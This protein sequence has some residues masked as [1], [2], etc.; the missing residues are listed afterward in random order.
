[1]KLRF[2][3]S[4]ADALTQ[5]MPVPAAVVTIDV[6][7]S[8]ISDGQKTLIARHLDGIDV[9]KLHYDAKTC[10][11]EKTYFWNGPNGDPGKRKPVRIQAAQPTFEAL[12]AAVAA[13][14][15]EVIGTGKSTASAAL[16]LMTCAYVF[17]TANQLELSLW[18]WTTLFS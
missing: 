1:M 9:L 18:Q 7:A 4:Q 15:A 11:L 2:E 5:G 13:N 16:R 14:Q 3:V 8:Q 12:M 10:R 6:S 17:L